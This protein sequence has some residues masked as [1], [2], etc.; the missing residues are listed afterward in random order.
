MKHKKE[1]E[2]G[3]KLMINTQLA[4]IGAGPAGLSA[5][6]EAAKYGVKVT[7]LD[8][9]SKPGGQ[10]FKQIHKFFG[11][12]EHKAGTRG[13]DIGSQLIEESKK[14]GVNVRMG[15][16]VYGA[17]DKN[18]LDITYEDKV[19]VLKAEK[20]IIATGASEKAL[21][22]PGWTMPG[23]MGAGAAQ[24]MINVNRV[25]PGKRILMIGSGNVGLIVS[26]QLLQAGAE[27]VALVEAADCIGGYGVHAAKIRRAGVPILTSHTVKCV[28]GTKCVESA[29]VVRVDN[30]FKPIEGTE[31]T[32]D[33]DMVCIAIGLYPLVELIK[34]FGCQTA[35]LPVLG[36]FV[37]LHDESMETS[38][39]GVYV[40]GDL[41]GVEEASTAM[42]EGK[43]AGLAVAHSLGYITNEEYDL[44]SESIKG[45]IDSLRMGQFGQKRKEA[46]DFLVGG[47]SDV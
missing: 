21:C 15:N 19:E 2:G 16:V 33:V 13:F 35:Y 8:E 47:A 7:L 28:T 17:F 38:I 25:L 9:N 37:P 23:V 11:S 3:E 1:M 20:I 41:A 32:F 40:A 44:R 43:L 29:T 18:Y 12:K 6:I 10:L 14:Y 30:N 22:F 39:P 34:I 24:T 45:Q 42:E 31:K 46:V 26:Y 4:V 36:G 5:A 27:V